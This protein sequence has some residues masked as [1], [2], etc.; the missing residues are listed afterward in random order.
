MAT[1][2]ARRV[3]P[4]QVPLADAVANG[5]H[6]ALTVLSLTGQ[7]RLLNDALRDRIHQD[8]R[9][10]AMPAT[11]A[12]FER[13]VDEGV[14]VCVAGSG[15]SLLAFERERGAVADPGEGWRVLRPAI[16]TR[17]AIVEAA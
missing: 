17:G 5:A 12:L 8:V 6:A 9:L 15:P 16:A 10:S 4:R 3:L 11:K 7:P 1:T 14:P 13:L 2:E